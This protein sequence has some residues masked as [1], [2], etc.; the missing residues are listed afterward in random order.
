M[1]GAPRLPQERAAD[2][3]SADEAP[4]ASRRPGGARGMSARDDA[5]PSGFRQPAR[6]DEYLIFHLHASTRAATAGID[7][8]L[9]R[10]VGISRRDW[11]VLAFLAESPQGQGLTAL[12]ASAGLD[13]VVA[14][15]LVASLVDRGLVARTRDV[16]DGR[17]VVLRLTTRGEDRHAAARVATTRYNTRLA[18]CLSAE[19]AEM[20]E[21]VLPRLAERA[22]QFWRA[23]RTE[24]S[25][26]PEG[27]PDPLHMAWR[28]SGSEDD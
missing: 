25:G 8:H 19:E 26:A 23:E 5:A 20:L 4:Q 18:A 12:A 3:P 7:V 1:S 21:A 9:R 13:K 11:R 17:A 27:W 6:L 10:T 15:R 2:I 28:P 16:Q 14:S 22:R 24:P